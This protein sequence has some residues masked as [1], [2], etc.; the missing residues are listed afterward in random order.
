M[1]QGIPESVRKCKD[2]DTCPVCMK[3]KQIRLPLNTD[4]SKAKR[5]LEIIHSDVCRP[6]DPTTYDD[7]KYFFTCVDDYTH[8][9]KIYL[10]ENKNEVYAFL[11]E[12]I[13]EAECH[14][15]TK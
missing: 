13:N 11:K 15:N 6:T 14:F 1:C 4:R 10:L 12:C 2:Y 8:F 3:A 9:C 7:K 5:P